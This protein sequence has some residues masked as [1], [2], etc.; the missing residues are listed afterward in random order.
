M[1]RAGPAFRVLV[2][3][4]SVSI[5]GP[6]GVGNSQPVLAAER[7]IQRSKHPEDLLNEV[8]RVARQNLD[9]PSETDAVV[10]TTERVFVGSGWEAS[11]RKIVRELELVLAS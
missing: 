9:H 3:L 2:L 10:K 4:C 5:V 1:K 6:V 7:V 8:V 11:F